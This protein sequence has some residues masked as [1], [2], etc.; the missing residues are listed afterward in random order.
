MKRSSQV[1]LV[2]M[3]VTATTAAGAYMMPA[4]SSECRSAGQRAAPAT[5]RRDTRAAAQQE[6]CPRRRSSWGSWNWGSAHRPTKGGVRVLEPSVGLGLDRVVAVEIDQQH[7]HAPGTVGFKSTSRSL[8]AF[9]V[10][11]RLRIDQSRVLVFGK[12]RS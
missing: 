6:P 5:E 4:R 1:A 2:L 9:D 10:A 3:G 7:E 8:R 11:R 12:L